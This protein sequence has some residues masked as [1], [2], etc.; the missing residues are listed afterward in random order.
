MVASIGAGQASRALEDARSNEQAKRGE[1]TYLD[2]CARC[3]AETL[4]GTEFGPA[5]VGNEFV[6]NWAGKNIG[7]MF[8]RVRDT[9]PIDGPGRLSA[10][11]SVDV[12]AFILHENNCNRG[13]QPLAADLAAL[14]AI[15]INAGAVR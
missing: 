5:L 11:Q 6:R 13:D 2:E 8:V 7:E 14:R 15:I 3:H 9:M 1:A 12:V 10:Q 4:S